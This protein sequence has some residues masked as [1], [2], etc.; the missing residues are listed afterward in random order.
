MSH[1]QACTCLVCFFTPMV[2]S[3]TDNSIAFTSNGQFSL[4][5]LPSAPT[6]SLGIRVP[7]G[8]T[9]RTDP[10]SLSQPSR[11]GAERCA[12]LI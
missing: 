5:A 3:S 6:S 8:H 10:L 7:A 11:D 4:W 2:C 9:M 12:A 1:A